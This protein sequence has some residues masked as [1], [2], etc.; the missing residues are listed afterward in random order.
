MQR[1]KG[2]DIFER[3][4]VLTCRVNDARGIDF[5]SLRTL[6]PFAAHPVFTVGL[7][8]RAHRAAC[9]QPPTELSAKRKL[10]R[11]LHGEKD[12]ASRMVLGRR[13]DAHSTALRAPAR[14]FLTRL[15]IGSRLFQQ[16]KGK[17]SHH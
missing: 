17:E 4:P 6:C 1:G 10:L 7:P 2:G 9:F 15:V 11:I 12:G 13:R 16:P 8:G 3:R 5:L 14:R